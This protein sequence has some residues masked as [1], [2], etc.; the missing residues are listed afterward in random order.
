MRVDSCVSAERH[1]SAA[2][3]CAPEVL[4]LQLA[5][6]ALLLDGLG[7]HAGLGALLQDEIVVV[8]VEDQKCAVLFR[9]RDAFVVD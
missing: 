8:D 2:Q 5:Q 9:E 3:Q 6:V 4:A 1:A 7:K